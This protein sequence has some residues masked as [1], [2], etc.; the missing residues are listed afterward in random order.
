MIFFRS[1][2]HK[3]WFSTAFLLIILMVIGQAAYILSLGKVEKDWSQLF[4]EELLQPTIEIVQISEDFG[5]QA[6][7]DYIK[8]INREKNFILTNVD[9]NRPNRRDESVRLSN[10]QAV[11]FFYFLDENR[12]PILLEIRNDQRISQFFSSTIGG[13]VLRTI[14]LILLS[15]I[16]TFFWVR[17]FSQPLEEFSSYVKRIS[18]GEMNVRIPERLTAQA[19]EVGDLAV[20]FNYMIDNIAE[21]QENQKRLLSDIAHELRSPLSRQKL[22]LT[23]LQDPKVQNDSDAFYQYIDRAEMEADRLNELINEVMIYLREGRNSQE[24][25]TLEK[26]SLTSMLESIIDDANFEFSQHHRSI[27]AYLPINIFVSG[28][29]I[30]L[31]RALENIIRNALFYTHDNTI[32]FVSLQVMRHYAVID[33]IDDGDGVPAEHLPF[34]TKPFYRTDEARN[35]RQGGYGLGLAI[36]QEII[37]RHHGS[38]EFKQHESKGLQVTIKLPLFNEEHQN[39]EPKNLNKMES[40]EQESMF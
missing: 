35:Q 32:V 25:T 27:E 26:L 9:V 10:H 1:Y 39:T 19:N 40:I 14:P 12:N 3:V 20:R 38:I 36:T 16:L 24:V 5:I 11:I 30:R 31:E 8:S 29:F 23:L 7:R 13:F 33:V 37:E 21:L 18:D 15:F 17:R 6:G 34:I 28:D 4:R 2:F 22:A